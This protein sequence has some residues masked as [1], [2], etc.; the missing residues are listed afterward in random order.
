[1]SRA[2]TVALCTATLAL[3]G[4]GGGDSTGSVTTTTT[5]PKPPPKETRDQLPNRPHEWKRYVN[6]RGG[7]ALL[8]PRGWE[9][10]T[11]RSASLIR[12]FDRLV[13]ISIVPDRSRAGL[14]TAIG[15][16]ATETTD[17]LRGFARAPRIRGRRPFGHRYDG[18]E[19][20]GTARA[21]GGIDQ[22]ISVIVLRRKGLATFTALLA[23]N[24][25]PAA[26]HSERIARR[27]LGTLRSRPPQSRSGRSG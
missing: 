19:V 17:G 4:C 1:M 14:E 23:A 8:L 7:F 24:A 12:S 2:A 27:V 11:R 3:A 16:Y 5:S 13:A 26:R 21:K 10:K 25:K 9:P 6:E 18:V 22:R 20:F 15:D